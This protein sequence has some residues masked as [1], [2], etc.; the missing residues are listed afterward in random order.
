MNTA[1]KLAHLFGRGSVQVILVYSS[2]GMPQELVLLL[3]VVHQHTLSIILLLDVEWLAQLTVALF[4]EWL[5]S[6]R[7]KHVE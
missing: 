2:S 4:A 3:V 1:G 7:Y 6:L 5:T